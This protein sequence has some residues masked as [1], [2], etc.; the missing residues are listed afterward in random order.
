M[1]TEAIKESVI[2]NYKILSEKS[3][4]KIAIVIILSLLLIAGQSY[5]SYF[6]YKTYS[7]IEEFKE[8]PTSV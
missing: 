2:N 6:I 4:V 1:K 5:A 7:S 8:I 3:K